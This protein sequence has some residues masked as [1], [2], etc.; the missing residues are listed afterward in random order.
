MSNIQ[1]ARK[2]HSRDLGALSFQEVVQATGLKWETRYFL[3]G[4]RFICNFFTYS[5]P[6]GIQNFWRNAVNLYDS[7]RNGGLFLLVPIGGERRYSTPTWA[8]YPPQVAI[9]D[10]ASEKAD[11]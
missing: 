5:L 3:A 9:L 8:S 4:H 1:F 10:R 6:A 7:F 11:D 2:V